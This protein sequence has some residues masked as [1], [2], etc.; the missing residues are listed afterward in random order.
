MLR[1][2]KLESVGCRRVLR[3]RLCRRSIFCARA[4]PFSFPSRENFRFLSGFSLKSFSEMKTERK[5]IQIQYSALIGQNYESF[6]ESAFWGWLIA[7][8]L[9]RKIKSLGKEY[10]CCEELIGKQNNTWF[11]HNIINIWQTN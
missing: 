1:R 11:L 9:R 3:W 4:L 2:K 5:M 7:R 10:L 6:H 8:S